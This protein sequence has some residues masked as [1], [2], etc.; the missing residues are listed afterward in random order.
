MRPR[1]VTVVHLVAVTAL[2][3]SVLPARP[4]GQDAGDAK[5]AAGSIRRLPDGKPDLSGYYMPDA[6][7]ANYGLAKHAQDFLTPA[8]RGVI[9]DPADG[10]LPEL[11]WASAEQ[12]SRE[13]PERGYEDP[14]AHCFVAGVPR[15]MY[16]PSPLHILQPPDH[17]IL[18]FER[19]SW[20][21]ITLRERP[22]LPDRIRL[23]QGDSMGRW[24]GDTLV[25]ETKNLNGKTWLNE[26]GEIVSHAE[27]VVERFTPINADLIEYR[28]TVTDPLVY[29][30]PWTILI[31]LNR[32]AD[33]LLEVACHEDNEDLEHLRHVRDDARAKA[34][35][36][37][38]NA[39]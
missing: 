3:L 10:T 5:A 2:C 13:R 35:G 23:W 1:A 27:E 32:M 18:L 38:E 7:G 22:R 26:V 6:G 21:N 25:V 17:V 33:E 12:V 31:P 29:S 8:G 11:P 28:A 20:R 9:V 39:R 4:T 19:T 30:R 15:S 14:T 36:Q 24:D 16:T 37:K 34:R